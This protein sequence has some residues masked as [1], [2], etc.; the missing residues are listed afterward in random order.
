MP[1]PDLLN[2]GPDEPHFVVEMDD[3]RRATLRFG[4]DVMGKR[5]IPA[6]SF[7][8]T[9][10]A[11][12]GT[13]GNVG[14]GTLTHLDE[15]MDGILS[16]PESSAGCRR[17]RPRADRAGAA[18]RAHGLPHPGTRRHR[19]GLCRD[20][21]A[22]PRGAE[23]GCAT[24]W[25]GSWYA[26]C[27]H[28]G[29]RGGQPVDDDFKQEIGRIWSGSAWPATTCRWTAVAWSRW[30]SR[31]TVCLTP[32]YL[33]DPA[34]QV[35]AGRLQ[36]PGSSRRPPRLLPSGQPHV[37]PARLPSQVIATAMQ[38]PGVAWMTWTTRLRSDR[39]RRLGRDR[40]TCGS[41]AA[42]STMGRLEIARVD[43]DPRRPEHGKHRVHPW[44]AAYEQRQPR[45]PG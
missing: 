31:M 23:G 27:R 39:F 11:G 35:V 3:D 18:V 38:A 9:C 28:G 20:G 40:R 13:A 45:G 33:R 25:T 19:G 4:D 5:P 42:G 21:R 24:R 16:G 26:A 37:R 41:K 43:N 15:K 2:S 30:I 12:N 7:T 34:K 10:R 29:P 44:R 6:T 36:R 1:C 32:G 8:V 17:R 14:A 22:S